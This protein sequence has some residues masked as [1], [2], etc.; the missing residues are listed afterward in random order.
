MARSSQDQWDQPCSDE[1]LC[2]IAQSIAE[3]K[4]IAPFLGIKATDE[5][6]IA[7][8]GP[9]IAQKV[10]MLRKWKQS[11]G[12]E[13]TYKKLAEAFRRCNRKDLVDKISELLTGN[14]SSSDKAGMLFCISRV[15]VS[16]F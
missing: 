9:V 4:G 10:A 7:Y 8:S 1:H 14:G 13:A 5:V 2:I 12:A 6:E 16:Y 15:R 11:L 3:W